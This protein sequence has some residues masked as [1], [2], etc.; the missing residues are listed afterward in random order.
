LILS[1][2]DKLQ[3]RARGLMRDG[4]VDHRLAIPVEV[5][6]D[7]CAR[8]LKLALLPPPRDANEVTD[9]GPAVRQGR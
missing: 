3:A 6:F 9:Q 7:R 1:D 5:A 2:L 8:E 4:N